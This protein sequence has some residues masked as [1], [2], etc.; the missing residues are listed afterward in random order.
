[1][2]DLLDKMVEWCNDKKLEEQSMQKMYE[3]DNGESFI[4]S[5]ELAAI[6]RAKQSVFDLVIWKLS[7]LK[8]S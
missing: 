5:E 8:E 6:S 7:K 4:N 3:K 2:K 1:M